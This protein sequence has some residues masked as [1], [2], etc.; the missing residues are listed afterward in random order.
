M[1]KPLAS[2]AM[3]ALLSQVATRY[4]AGPEVADAQRVMQR[5]AAQ[6]LGS[7]LGYWDKPA[8]A[9]QLVLQQYLESI[10]AFTS[11]WSHATALDPS[12]FGAGNKPD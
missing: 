1:F 11:L 7:T 12:F 8:E 3:R 2:R 9:P 4:I 5:Y 6:N 10:Q